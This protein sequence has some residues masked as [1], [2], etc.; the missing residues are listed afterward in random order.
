MS[1]ELSLVDALEHLM[2]QQITKHALARY[3][4][5]WRF[6][7]NRSHFDDL[8]SNLLAANADGVKIQDGVAAVGFCAWHD[9][10]YDPQ[11]AHGRNEM[12]SALLCEAEMP[13]I[14]HTASVHAA[15]TT[16]LATIGHWLPNSNVSPDGALLLDIDLGILGGDREKFD[17]YNA[18]IRMEYQHVSEQK[19]REGRARV[20]ETFLSRERLFMTEWAHS[21]WEDRARENLTRARD[22]LKA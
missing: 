17:N 21:K 2:P 1:H 12:L 10:I 13:S 4:E 18:N 11:A 14:A 15:K 6:Y 22:E 20:L 19:Y 16:I 9:S 3:D 5:P 8:I 7:H